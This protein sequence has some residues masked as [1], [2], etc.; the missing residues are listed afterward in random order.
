MDFVIT[1]FLTMLRFQPPVRTKFER[2][3]ATDPDT[4]T[5]LENAALP[6]PSA[7]GL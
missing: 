3:I 4:L 5:D 7:H 6:P 2:L 1:A